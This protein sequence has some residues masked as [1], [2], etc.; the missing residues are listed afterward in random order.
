M[1]YP[2]Y[3]LVSFLKIFNVGGL[4]VR[5]GSAYEGSTSRILTR[6]QIALFRRGF[7]SP[8]G[9]LFKSMCPQLGLVRQRHIGSGKQT[10]RI[11]GGGELGTL[12]KHQQGY[13][14]CI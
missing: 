10:G 5:R 8:S 13:I 11:K 9:N 2:T 7:E 3:F 12:V 1:T 4:F 6:G 14:L